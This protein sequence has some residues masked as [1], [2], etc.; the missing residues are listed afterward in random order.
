MLSVSSAAL[1]VTWVGGHLD[2]SDDEHINVDVAVAQE[3]R[4]AFCEHVASGGP[5]L[6]TASTFQIRPR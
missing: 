4:D 1:E 3:I 5:N 2:L 6:S